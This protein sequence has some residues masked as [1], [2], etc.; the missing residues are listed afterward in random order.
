VRA[1]AW[2]RVHSR[3][4]PTSI[5]KWPCPRSPGAHLPTRLVHQHLTRDALGESA[6]LVVYASI[7]SSEAV[8]LQQALGEWDAVQR[9]PGSSTTAAEH[10]PRFFSERK[11]S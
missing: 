6:R 4:K 10:A 1:S 5:G 11:A 7:T 9:L 3:R 8:E 2:P